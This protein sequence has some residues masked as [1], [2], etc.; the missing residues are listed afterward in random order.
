MNSLLLKDAGKFVRNQLIHLKA[1]RLKR[2]PPDRIRQE[3]QSWF[4][5]QLGYHL[6]LDNPKTLCEKIQWLKLWDS[7][8][9]K[10]ELSD[11]YCVREWVAAKIG[12]DHLIPLLGDWGSI[13]DIDPASL[14]DEFMLKSSGGSGCNIL[15][16]D[17]SILNDRRIKVQF[18]QSLRSDF[19]YTFGF[20]LHYSFVK[21]RI[22]AEQYMD[23]G[24][25]G[26]ADYRFFCSYGEVFSIWVDHG[27][28]AHD[29]RRAVF[30]P[31]WTRVPV[32]TG[33]ADEPRR[34]LAPSSLNEMISI[35]QIL[36]R[37]FS[38]VR[39]DLYDWHGKV[40]FGEMT[41]TPQSGA[42]RFDPIGYDALFG[43]MVRLPDEKKK[44]K[45]VLL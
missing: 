31:D 19:A 33:R 7:T 34:L 17:K 8:E 36:S 9:Q 26:P 28:L 35:A 2:L 32:N 44:F 15:V 3:L 6:N 24:E 16:R 29:Y 21:P 11:K 23:F 22:I 4:Y 12:D 40:M 41:F 30:T 43:S 10:G 5:G 42:I 18:D 1:E 25:D 45:G 27:S 37:E 20:E 38:L 39:V 13:D 14:P